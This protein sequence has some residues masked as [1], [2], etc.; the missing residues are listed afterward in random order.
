MSISVEKAVIA[1]LRYKDKNFEI[2]VDPYR[3]IDVKRGIEVPLEELVVIPEVFEDSAKGEKCS[4]EDLNKAFGTSDF[5]EIAFHIIRKGEVQLTTE[6]RRKMREKKR[7]EIA[8]IISRRAIDPQR[9]VPHTP[10]RIMN[11]MEEAKVRIDEMK[12]AEAQI[13]SVIDSIKAVIPISIESLEI[14]VK[15]PPQ[16][17]GKAYGKVAEFGKLKKDEWRNDGS[18]VA[19]IEIP[20]GLQGE[21]YNLL[22][23]LTKGEAE[24]KI[25]KKS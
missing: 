15:I 22:N 3:A 14:M 9:N 19:T 12:P 4:S 10:Q 18:W 21:F 7:K 23:S 20:A 5:K 11:A 17:T 16:Y 24:A 25:V 6:Q 1:R 8:D 13:E 2:L